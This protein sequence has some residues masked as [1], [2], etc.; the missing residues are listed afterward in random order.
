M[1]R[2]TRAVPRIDPWRVAVLVLL[3]SASA[4]L[5]AGDDGRWY[6]QFRFGESMPFSRAHD[7]VGVTVGRNLTRHLGLELAADFYEVFV[8]QPGVGKVAECGTGTIVPQLRLRHAFLDDRLVAYA[9][10]GV[11]AALTQL[12]D[13]TSDT[14]GTSISLDDAAFVGALGAGVEYLVAD[15]V[16][17][18][19]EG[20]HLFASTQTL[21]YGA[22][23]RDFDVDASLFALSMRLLFPQVDTTRAAA[24][25]APSS[26][27]FYVGLRAGFAKPVHRHVF[28]PVRAEPEA[29]N[30]GPFDQL[31]GFALGAQ[32]GRYLG[33]E[34]PIEGYEV[35]LDLPGFG[36]L[37]E[38][39]VYSLVPQARVRYPLFDERLWPYALG[40]VGM[41]FGEFNDPAPG[42][43]RIGF[44]HGEDSTNLA[45][46][47]G[48][49]LEWFVASNVSLTGEA[50]YLFA[51]G[52]TL[53]IGEDTRYGGNFDSLFLTIGL[54]VYLLRLG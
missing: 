1:D 13:R 44:V 41:S 6:T 16:A 7:A 38:Y 35:R 39:A 54:R 5:A 11:G 23:R 3:S 36:S 43:G 15:N 8:D 48:G 21:R 19:V 22:T 52:Q 29:A 27:T 42:I 26:T 31:Y 30:V 51:R 49:G 46:I 47:L 53:R 40:G 50:R 33:V 18:G 17:V 2:A 28:G 37:G 24:P 20:K 12:N 25:G 4:S 34:L 9:I 45:G 32:I 14:A 10:G